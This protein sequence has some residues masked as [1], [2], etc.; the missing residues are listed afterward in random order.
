LAESNADAKLKCTYFPDVIKGVVGV[1]KL[2][3]ILLSAVES[4]FNVKMKQTKIF[5]QTQ[6]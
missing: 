1:K 6:K 3:S 2:K 4:R 5:R